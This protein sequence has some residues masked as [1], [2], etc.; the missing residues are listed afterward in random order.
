MPPVVEAVIQAARRCERDREVECT[1]IEPA[2]EPSRRDAMHPHHLRPWRNAPVAFDSD[3][4]KRRYAEDTAECRERCVLEV[5]SVRR[6]GTMIVFPE[7]VMFA[8]HGD[9]CE[10]MS[11]AVTPAC[12]RTTRSAFLRELQS[13]TLEAGGF[14]LTVYRKAAS[15]ERA[16]VVV[17]DEVHIEVR[18]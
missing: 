1:V 10:A 14:R 12:G 4:R 9:E 18:V 11:R 3:V 13:R 6:Y 7:T 17:A 5:R 16:E 2:S 8:Q 15:Q